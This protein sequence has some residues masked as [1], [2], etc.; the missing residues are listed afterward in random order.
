MPLS[1]LVEKPRAEA[2][3]RASSPACRARP[4]TFLARLPRPARYI[5]APRALGSTWDRARRRCVNWGRP[6]PTGRIPPTEPTSSVCNVR[7][8]AIVAGQWKGGWPR[9]LQWH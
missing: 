5:F 9:A 1:H 3:A 6:L 4:A 2:G 7:L 8:G